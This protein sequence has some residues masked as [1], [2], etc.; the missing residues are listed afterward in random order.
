VTTIEC[1]LHGLKRCLTEWWL[2]F[3]KNSN[4]SLNVSVINADK[5]L[6]FYRRQ[7]QLITPE[8]DENKND[9]LNL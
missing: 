5:P 6:R 2:I 7:V 4:L 3:E 1:F 9:I 8:D